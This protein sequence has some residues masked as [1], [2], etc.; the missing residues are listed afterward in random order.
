MEGTGVGRDTTGGLKESREVFPDTAPKDRV[1]CGEVVK[2][3]G[4]P[5]ELFYVY[6][7]E[8]LP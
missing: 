3:H 5:N 4:A 2:R 6:L 1:N 7:I 8:I